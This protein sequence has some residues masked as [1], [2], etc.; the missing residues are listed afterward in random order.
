MER[1]APRDGMARRRQ[2]AGCGNH[3]RDSQGK[4]ELIH[5]PLHPTIAKTL[6]SWEQVAETPHLLG[7]QTSL[8]H[9]PTPFKSRDNRHSAKSQ[10]SMRPVSP[11]LS[12]LTAFALRVGRHGWQRRRCAGEG[13]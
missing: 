5:F 4:K 11:G 1:W 8:E 2:V 3:L 6:V 9:F 12:C 13:V 7:P 10:L